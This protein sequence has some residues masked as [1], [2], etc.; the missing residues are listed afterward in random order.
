MKTTGTSYHL[1]NFVDAKVD[2]GLQAYLDQAGK[3]GK[4]YR[5]IAKELTERTG[6]SVSKSAVGRWITQG[7]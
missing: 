1:F 3:E 2:G 7:R 5:G 4:T 6:I